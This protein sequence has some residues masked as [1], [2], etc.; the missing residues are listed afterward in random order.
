MDRAAK[1]RRIVAIASG[2]GHWVQLQRLRPAFEGCDVA[3]VSV[4]P[5]YA[6]DLDGARFY[7]VTDVS[8]VNLKQLLVIVPQFI[9]IMLRERP[10]VV[11]TTGSAPGLIGLAVARL[12]TGAKTIWIDSIANCE[13]LSSSGRQARRV[14]HQWL[15]QWPELARP[16]GPHY[17]GAV[18]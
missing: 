6:D 8:R 10:D 11:I 17:W 18:L 2:G 14:A 1:P 5:D 12:T 4:Y 9:A 15:T 13:R 16:E 7:T 3:Y